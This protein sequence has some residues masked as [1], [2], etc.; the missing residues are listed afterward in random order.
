[1]TPWVGPYAIA[2]VL[3]AVAGAAKAASPTATA[4]ALRALGLPGRPV[5][6]RIG[7]AAEAGLAAAA[8]ATG[9]VPLVVAVGASYLVFAAFVVA[10]LRA[11]V[12][13]ASCGCLGRVDTPPHAVHVGVV[14]PCDREFR[15][16][17]VPRSRHVVH[18]R[19]NGGNLDRCRGGKRR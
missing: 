13:V 5:W 3:L 2:A 8:L 4:G 10:A 18:R 7:G 14:A 16:V 1:M 11:G 9:W 19:R 6:V 15:S 17:R 12:P